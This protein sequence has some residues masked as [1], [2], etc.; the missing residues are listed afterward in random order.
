MRAP[1]PRPLV[2]LRDLP[3]A[4]GLLTRL[5]AGGPGRGA[6]SAWAWPVAGAVVGGLAAAAAL[7]ALAAGLPAG[8]AA[9]AALAVQAL[10]TG[11]LH[12]DGL[13]D[14][15]DGIWGGRTP[16]RRLEI[17]KDSRIGSYGVL[18]LLLV[19]LLRWS[20]LAALLHPGAGWGV[21]AGLIAL[22]ALSRVP[23]AVMMTAL[24]PARGTGLSQGMGRPHP[25]TAALA[26]V[27]GLGL[28]LPL[29][30]GAALAL[31]L[32]CG[33]PALWLGAV[34]RRRIGGQTGDVLGATQQ[35]SEAAGLAILVVIAG[36]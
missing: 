27:A 2:A 9:G 34:A 17:M 7:G 24:P 33:L 23:M 32:A 1:L 10:A 13:G 3:G 5:P 35:L 12:E 28:A 16:E 18:A 22:G 21:V 31:A 8:V 11:A 29:G 6:A 25:A 19:T 14:T 30:P 4:F 15:A 26:T 20:A 36:A